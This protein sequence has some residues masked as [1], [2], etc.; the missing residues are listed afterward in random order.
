VS[1]RDESWTVL[2]TWGPGP[3]G[4]RIDPPELPELLG[5]RSNEAIN[6]MKYYS[7]TL[8]FLD[9]GAGVVRV[10]RVSTDMKLFEKEMAH[11]RIIGH[12]IINEYHACEL[13]PKVLENLQM[14]SFEQGEKHTYKA[15]NDSVAWVVPS[16]DYR[17]WRNAKDAREKAG[18]KRP[19][20]DLASLRP[21]RGERAAPAATPLPVV[22]VYLARIHL[23]ATPAVG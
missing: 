20:F 13:P 3:A 17:A 11:N 7:R 23:P 6:S 16:T 18:S 22:P 8:F 2:R 12:S 10:T 21:K 15:T 5:F 14:R 1:S 9:R 4:L 19:R